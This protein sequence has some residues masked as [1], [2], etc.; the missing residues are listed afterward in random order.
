MIPIPFP[1]TCQ[2][3][4][5]PQL[6]KLDQHGSFESSRIIFRGEKTLSEARTGVVVA[7]LVS[8]SIYKHGKVRKFSLLVVYPTQSGKPHFVRQDLKHNRIV[9]E[10][11]KIIGIFW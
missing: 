8:V 9:Y 6:K 11:Q 7:C 3:G 2:V 5:L 10:E 1:Q 4:E